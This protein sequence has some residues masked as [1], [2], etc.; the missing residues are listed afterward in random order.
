MS[1]LC[2]SVCPQVEAPERGQLQQLGRDGLQLVAGQ[3]EA[4][5]AGQLAQALGEVSLGQ[6]VAGEQEV[7]QPAQLA[8]A[9]RQR[10]QSVVREVQPREPR[11]E[12]EGVRQLGDGVVR[13][14]EGGEGAGARGLDVVGEPQLQVLAVKLAVG[15]AQLVRAAAKQSVTSAEDDIT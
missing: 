11:V 4:A 6:E 14:G 12:G 2:D 10:G 1:H 7:G 13:G 15:Q 3:V 5:E 9:G 8:Q